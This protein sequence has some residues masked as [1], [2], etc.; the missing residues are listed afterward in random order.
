MV[1]S[2]AEEM[3][4]GGMEITNEPCIILLRSWDV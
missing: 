1:F 2:I 3:K 4:D